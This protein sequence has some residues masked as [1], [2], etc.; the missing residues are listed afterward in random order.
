[1]L[2][3]KAFFSCTPIFENFLKNYELIL[4]STIYEKIND[5]FEY[6]FP[7][8]SGIVSLLQPEGPQFE[9]HKGYRCFFGFIIYFFAKFWWGFEFYIKLAIFQQFPAAMGPPFLY[10]ALKVIHA[11]LMGSAA[12]CRN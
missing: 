11:I 6:K 2:K 1:M 10:L 12:E 5:I 9:P 3:K 8:S 7:W 4:Q